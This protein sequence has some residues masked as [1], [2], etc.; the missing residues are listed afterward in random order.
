MCSRPELKSLDPIDREVVALRHFEQIGPHRG[1]PSARDHAG[2]AGAKR[3]FRA[4]KRV[5]DALATLPGEAH[6]ARGPLVETVPGHWVRQAED[7]H[8]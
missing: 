5:K 6:A 2:K 4:L 7:S 8:S 1:G 3:L